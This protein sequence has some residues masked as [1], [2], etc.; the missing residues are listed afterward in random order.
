MA[1]QNFPKELKLPG[2]RK[3]IVRLMTATDQERM[4]AF[5]RALPQDDLLFLRTDITDP[6]IIEE[7]AR[8]I[9][10][11]HTVTLLAEMNDDLVAY[12]SL[13]QNA[14]RWTRGVGEIRIIV[15]YPYR[16]TGLGRRMA[17]AIFEVAREHHLRKVTAMMTPDQTGARAVFEK[18]G[19]Q[20]EALLADWVEDRRGQPRDLLIMSH[21]VNGFSDSVAA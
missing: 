8:N 14:A 11:G 16:N 10:S 20:V 9:D 4:L 17:A 21:D 18:L 7:W 2:G 1:T 12:A 5:A 6:A 19:F 15:A 13:H 3:A